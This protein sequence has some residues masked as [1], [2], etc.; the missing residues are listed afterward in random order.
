MQHR[1]SDEVPAISLRGLV[2]ALRRQAV[3]ILVTTLLGA[4]L[5]TYVVL[6]QRP[7]YEARATLRMPEQQNAPTTDVLAALSGPS[8]IETE[9]EILRSRSVAEGVVQSLGLQVTVTEPRGVPRNSLFGVLS[10]ANNAR[11]GTYVIRRDTTAFSVTAPSGETMG[12]PYGMPLAVGGVTVEPLPLADTGRGA[13]QVTLAVAALSDAAEAVR[14]ELRVSR[15]Q[16][17]AGIVAV[18]YQST[19]P[20]LA[21]QVV[22]GVAQ[23]YIDQRG[24]RQKQTYSSTVQFLQT[25]VGLIG[26]QLR[27]AEDSLQQYRRAHNVIDPAAQAS[28]A[29]Q[30]RA[31]LQVQREEIDQQR[32]ALWTLLARSR[33]PAESVADWA[34]F[35]GSPALAGNPAI[36]AIMGQLVPLETERGQ[37]AGQRTAAEPQVAAL[38]TTI[39]TLRQ[40]LR[41]AATAT[42]RQ[43][44]D[45]YSSVDETLQRSNTQL[46]AVPEVQLQYTRLSRQ[47]DLNNELYTLLQKQ[48]KE[49]QISEASEVA[50]VGFVDSA[51]VPTRPLGGRRLFNLLFGLALSFLCGGLVGLARESADTRVRS[52][53]ELVRLTELPLLASI[54]RMQLT[55]GFRREPAARIEGRL[56]LRHAPRSPAA[57][58]YRALR[59]NVAF[60]GNGTRQ[61][62][63]TIVVTS[64]EPMDGKT[65]TAVNLSVTLAEQGHRVVL[66]E[67]DQRRPVLH[68]VLHTE[69]TPGLSD[70]LVGAAPL[71]RTLHPVALPAFATG[72]LH[73]IPAGHAPPNPAELLGSAAMQELL[74]TLGERFDTVVIDTPPLCV[75]TDAAVVGARADG[76]LMVARMGATHGDALRRSVEEMRGLGA[77]VVGT[78]LTDVSQREDR[79]G[80]RYG[81][82]EYYDE[83][84][85]HGNG[86][87]NGK[88]RGRS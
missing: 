52:R 64:A 1:D 34:E 50:S 39:G 88:R 47:V 43:L 11:P 75:V 74:A 83:D 14:A 23:S 71:E 76:V 10:V 87:G 32:K 13:A 22:N 48:L 16:A 41:S 19:D 81:H 31:N 80:Y 72:T 86:N 53:E 28:D 73:F 24:A 44:D 37:M 25:Q 49:S 61:P 38:I 4:G 85:A 21:M 84:G 5:T 55:N 79:Y 45:Q 60:A 12:S 66:I 2:A 9:M 3:W 18:A 58:A 36:T 7:E 6:R 17:N 70:L 27:H 69:R 29:V 78:V 63:K 40:R 65:T 35:I 8:T 56:V 77:R 57:E 51:A 26:E 54:P 68:T 20:V 67:G 33:Q 46:A 59:T 15:P 62:L 30:R 82:Y 42:L